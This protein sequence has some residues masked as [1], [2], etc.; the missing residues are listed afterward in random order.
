LRLAPEVAHR[1]CGHCQEFLYDEE[2]GLVRRQKFAKGDDGLGLPVLRRREPLPCQ[3]AAGCP[4][5]TP[6]RQLS[7]SE[8]NRR[9]YR[10]YQMCK[11]TGTWP[12][13]GMVRRN[14]GIIEAAI[15]S[16]EITQ[17]WLTKK[18]YERLEKILVESIKARVV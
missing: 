8:K 5:G 15:S 17:T 16:A 18:H 1:D 2:T 12:K 7:L 9:A 3:T 10:H 4:K 11:A 14:A 13:D 6:E